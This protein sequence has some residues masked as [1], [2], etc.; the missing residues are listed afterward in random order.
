MYDKLVRLSIGRDFSVFEPYTIKFSDIPNIVCQSNVLYSPAQ[1]KENR[2]KSANFL[3][4]ADFLVLDFDEGWNEYHEQLF[5]QY[6]GYKVPTKSHMKLKNDII[7]ERYRIILLLRNPIILD[8]S[9]YKR[10][11]KHIMKDLQLDS[12]TS[13]VDACRFYYSAKQPVTNCIKLAGTQYFP[14]EKYNYKD[15]QYA[16]LYKK[17]DIDIS[18]FKGLDVS[19]FSNLHRSKR[20]PCP[21]CRLEGFD[22]KG[23]HLG[24]NK[25]DDYPTCFFDEDHSKILRKIYKQYK[26]GKIE[27]EIEKVK[28]MVREKCTPDL[29]KVGRYNP[30]PTNYSEA[31]FDLYDKALDTIEKDNI[32]DLDIETFSEY[33]VAETYEEAENRLKAD[34]K[35]IKGAYN[36]KCDE[37]KGVAL[38]TFKNKI[39]IITLSGNNTVCPFDMYYVKESQ[40][41][42]ILNIVKNKIIVGH[43]LKF[44]IKSIMASYGEEYCPKYCY[45]TMIASR[46]IHMALDPE[47]QQIGHNLA[48]TAY[49]FLNYKMNKEVDHSWG[50]DNLTEEQLRYAGSDVTVL[51]PIFK[52]Q[53]RQFKEIYGPFDTVNYDINELAFLGPLVNEHPILALEMQTLLEVIRIEFT[54]V[55]PNI[56]MM[57]KKIDYYTN[58]IDNADAELGIN[59]GSSKQCVEYLKKYVDKSIESSDAGTLAKYIDD[60]KVL[61]I[62]E[63]KGA[64]TRRGLMISMSDTNLHPYDKRIHPNFNQL[65]N[66]GRFACSSPNMQQIPKDIKNT[67]YQSS[68]DGIVYD[69]DY[70]AVELRL[71]T[72]V[73]GDPVLLDAYKKNM[74]MHYLTAQRLFHKEIP[75]TL[76]EKEDAENNPNSKF[77]A[78]WHRGYAKSMNFGLIYGLHWTTFVATSIAGGFD[79]TEEEAHGYYDQ[80]FEVYKG[81]KAMIDNAKNVFLH[82]TNKKVYRWLRNKA[83]SFYKKEATTAFFTQCKTLIGRR[84]AVD[85]E[86]KMMNYPVQGSGA[87]TIK[88][89][90][91]KLGYNTRK[92]NTT[93][94]T[95]NLVHDD[96]IGECKVRDF[97]INSAYFRDAL[98]W[99]VNYVL[100]RQFFTPVDQDFCILSMF[101]EE[102][103]LEKARTLNEAKDA[104]LESMRHNYDK[105]EK[106]KND[107]K[108]EDIISLTTNLNTQYK[109]LTKLNQYLL[110][111]Q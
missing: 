103:F 6:I 90:I 21:I 60:P 36:A 101:G 66:T 12:D 28:D 20:Y 58:Y 99:A 87:D 81:L 100:R 96:T 78:K 44:D 88:L 70:A 1:Y 38:D 52:E 55:K 7:C 107:N 39:R 111:K 18:N 76:E 25:D 29:I 46:M 80:F 94:R 62:V 84:L 109:V 17:E 43:N 89:A 72:V 54:G 53:I 49:R 50:N 41:Q 64:R 37:Y 14:W 2:R 42:R 51:R 11:Y 75:H 56:P 9:D 24:F 8:Y 98:E 26:Y 31:I 79:M 97:D 95:I 22:K 68:E 30:K 59:C 106:A 82:G 40:K 16:S 104:L 85:T 105:L 47:E 61:K 45:D 4:Y 33:Y 73:S 71:V 93:H 35:Y 65:L 83:G 32:V 3:G 74:D 23:H 27:D 92:D 110:D 19:Y 91:C 10:L 108:Q 15:I 86:R 13:C 34:Y 67:I 57:E 48:A 69:A 102:V 5:N 77:L 63:S